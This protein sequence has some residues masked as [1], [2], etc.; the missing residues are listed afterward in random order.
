MDASYKQSTLTL[1]HINNIGLRYAETLAKWRRKFNG[2]NKLGD[3]LGE[4][5]GDALGEGECNI[6][7]DL[8]NGKLCF[9]LAAG[10]LHRGDVVD[11]P[12]STRHSPRPR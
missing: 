11:L 6:E 1:E 2:N 4:V 8:E 7:G 9:V 12:R 5:E 10:Y 3:K